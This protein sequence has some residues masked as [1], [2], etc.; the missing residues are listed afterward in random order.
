MGKTV[1]LQFITIP[2]GNMMNQWMELK[3][4]LALTWVFQHFETHPFNTDG[5]GC[6]KKHEALDMII[7]DNV[8]TQCLGVSHL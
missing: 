1:D 2:P 7:Y 5:M 6:Q 8:G 4:Q 3:K